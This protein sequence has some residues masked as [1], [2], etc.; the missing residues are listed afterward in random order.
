MITIMITIDTIGSRRPD[1]PAPDGRA[2]RG[3]LPAGDGLDEVTGARALEDEQA[4]PDPQS[5]AVGQDVAAFDATALDRDHTGARRDGELATLDRQLGV[6]LG[7]AGVDLDPD[8]ARGCLTDQRR[9][10]VAETEGLPSHAG[11]ARAHQPSHRDAASGPPA[12]EGVL[13]GDGDATRA[14]RA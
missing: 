1:L 10:A 13:D 7:D 14:R 11:T 5:L 9:C 12:A 6:L 3:G 2:R 8:A 4:G